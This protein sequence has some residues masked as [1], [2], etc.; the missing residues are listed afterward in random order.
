[1]AIREHTLT[2]HDLWQLSHSPEYSDQRLELVE[3]RL[4][5]MS[6]AGTNHGVIAL[7]LGAALVN[8]NRTTRLGYVTAAETGYFLARNPD[9]VRAPDAAFIRRNRLPDGPPVGYCPLPPDLAAEVVSPTDTAADI[10]TKVEEYLRAGVALIWVVYPATQTVVVHT[11][12]GAHTLTTAD[13]LTAD[14]VLSGFALPLAEL[15]DL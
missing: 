10:H 5:V 1:M 15:F 8:Y 9:T 11:P 3:G 2:A 12:S 4:I 14:P 6:P 7:A 13:T